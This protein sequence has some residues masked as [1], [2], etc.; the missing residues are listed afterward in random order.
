MFGNKN[1]LSSVTKKEQ[2]WNWNAKVEYRIRKVLI[3]LTKRASVICSPYTSSLSCSKIHCCKVL[4]PSTLFML[5][6]SRRDWERKNL[7]I[8]IHSQCCFKIHVFTS[9]QRISVENIRALSRCFRRVYIRET[10]ITHLMS[11]TLYESMEIN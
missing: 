5:W 10:Q 2:A 1:S 11:W 8:N 3:F 6:E 4:R 7:M 9:L